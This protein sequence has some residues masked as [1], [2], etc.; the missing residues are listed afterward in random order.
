MKKSIYQEAQWTPRNINKA[1]LKH[2]IIE[3]LKPVKR[4]KILKLATR[5]KKTLCTL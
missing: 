4:K 1:T 2:I 5:G 3:M